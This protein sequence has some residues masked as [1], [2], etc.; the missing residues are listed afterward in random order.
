M[1]I[2]ICSHT[3]IKPLPFHSSEIIAARQTSQISRYVWDNILIYQ[4]LQ[5]CLYFLT[6]TTKT[7]LCFISHS[8]APA[9]HR[10]CYSR[11]MKHRARNTGSKTWA[12][13]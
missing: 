12:L 10:H 13:G 6:T 11:V 8:H 2:E 7:L 4:S 1:K 5:S 3:I 9:L